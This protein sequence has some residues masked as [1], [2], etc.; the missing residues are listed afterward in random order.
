M[1]ASK[2]RS[3]GLGLGAA[4]VVGL[5]LGWLKSP[6]TEQVAFRRLLSTP[7]TFDMG[8]CAQGARLSGE[9]EVQNATDVPVLIERVSTG[10]GCLTAS[11]PDGRRLAPGATCRLRLEAETSIVFGDLRKRVTLYTTEPLESVHT[12]FVVIHVDQGLLTEG[13]RFDF[14]R[15]VV[16]RRATATIVL[17][18]LGRVEIAVTD[19]RLDG[20][21]VAVETQAL[22][23]DAG[24]QRTRLAI[25]VPGFRT[26][27]LH[28]GRVE[29]DVGESGP[30]VIRDYRALVIDRF[31]VEPALVGF[32]FVEVGEG[33]Q[34]RRVLL[35]D[36]LAK[37]PVA[38]RRLATD[39]AELWTA[40]VKGVEGEFV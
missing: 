7:D 9:V 37:K 21:Q 38:V 13:H 29:I 28:T 32:G 6:D 8:H 35:R 31:V 17:R 27:G 34:E 33:G 24:S 40:E 20:R 22:E 26:T 5:G 30:S 36:A 4:F 18:R 10:C 3:I 1:R 2:L 16:D 39:N 14:G 23:S 12:F 25:S 19:V 11:L 15:V